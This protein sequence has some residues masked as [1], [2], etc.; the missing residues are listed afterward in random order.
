MKC[1]KL[2]SHKKQLFYHRFFDHCF[3]YGGMF[4]SESGEDFA[5]KLDMVRFQGVY[6]LTV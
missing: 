1:S 4:L 3:K 5:V 6:Q 2:F